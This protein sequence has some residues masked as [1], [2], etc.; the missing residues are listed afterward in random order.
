MVAVVIFASNIGSFTIEVDD[1]SKSIILSKNQDFKSP[2]R[3]LSAKPLSLG[4]DVTY[5]THV[6]GY[7]V[8]DNFNEEF[9]ERARTYEGSYESATV[10]VLA[11]TFYLKNTGIEDI[12]LN[13]NLDI[14]D[15]KNNM[16]SA[17]RVLL[18]YS[19]ID[20]NNEVRKLYGKQDD[21][22][23]LETEEEKKYFGEY[24]LNNTL[25]Y[26]DKVIFSEYINNI[27]KEEIK[28]ISIFMWI[29]GRDPDCNDSLAINRGLLKT[30]LNIKI[31]KE[32]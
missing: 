25:F 23:L 27:K 19:D 22:G 20:N 18:I 31:I 21:I 15:E 32:D 2:T 12:N 16:S 9:I 4:D 13:L 28:K 17:I 8:E 3:V 24:P 5:T 26:N 7:L 10:R 30:K 29:E 11:Y 6:T 1:L 14:L